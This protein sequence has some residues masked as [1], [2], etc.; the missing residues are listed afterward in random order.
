MGISSLSHKGLMEKAVKEGSRDVLE[1]ERWLQEMSAKRIIVH[2]TEYER[3][4]LLGLKAEG[5]TSTW[6]LTRSRILLKAS[7]DGFLMLKH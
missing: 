1:H 2:L 4:T 3:S 7:T 6:F 5:I